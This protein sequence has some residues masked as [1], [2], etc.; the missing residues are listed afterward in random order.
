MYKSLSLYSF[1][2]LLNACLFLKELEEIENSRKIYF[3]R[4]VKIK[5]L[6][7]TR[8]KIGQK[9][10]SQSIHIFIINDKRS[11]TILF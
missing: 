11:R 5:L 9:I 3:E 7:R 8:A 4:E 2:I 10:K 6:S 1:Y